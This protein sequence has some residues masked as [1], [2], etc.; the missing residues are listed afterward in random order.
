M[1]LSRASG[2]RG[3]RRGT[4]VLAAVVLALTGASAVTTTAAP[5]PAE[6]AITQQVLFRKGT[7]GYGCYRIPAI[8]RTNANTLLAFAEAR[9][10]YC[11]DAGHIDLVM[12]R[13][14]D[15]GRT[16]SPPV[17]QAPRIVLQGTDS[18]PTAAATRG[19]P[20]PIVGE[21]GRVVLLSTFNPGD[22]TRPRTPY[23][24]TSDDNGETWSAAR[25]LGSA[26]DDPT[27][28]WYAT[29][30]SHG[31]R[32]ERG[33]HAGRLVAGVNFSDGDGRNG[34]ALV[35]S[36][37]GGDT[38]VR[39]ATDIRTDT[40]LVPQEL[41]LFER[42]DGGIYAAA[43]DNNGA[44]GAK[45]A[46]AVS[47]DGGASFDAPF[48]GVADV[49]STPEVQGS[50]LRLR[51]ADRGDRYNRVLLASPADPS[52]RKYL[53]I[54]SS[55]DEGRTWTGTTPKRIASD[56]SGYSD[57]VELATGEI[58]ALYEGGP[59]SGDARDEIRFTR[60]TESDLGL[61]DTYSGTATPDLSGA[62]ND[63]YL[64]GG[65]ALG[66]AGRFDEAVTLDGADDYL[67]LPFSES[68]AIGT[69]DFTAMA[70]IRYGASTADQAIFWGYGQDDH[71]Q[72]WLRA[73]P[74]S[75]RIRGL[76]QSG[77]TSAV[78]AS[79][80]A[81]NDNAWHHVALQ[82][83]AGQLRLWVDGAVV[84]SAAAPTGTIS[85]GRPFR[86]YA[87]QRLDGANRFKG[88]LDEVRLYKRALSG[89]EIGA[90]RGANAIDVP[91]AVLRLPFVAA[92]PSTPDTSGAGN[93]A[94]VRGG[95]ALT[96]GRYGSALALDGADD[97]VQLPFSS[98]LDLGAGDFTVSAWLRYSG[99]TGRH[100][101]LWAYGLGTDTAQLWLRAHPAENR[102]LGWAETETASG[103]A[104]ST[105]GYA[106]GAWHHV[107]FQ[108][109]G[110]ELRLLV[111]GE[112]VGTAAAPAG[113]LTGGHAA[114]VLGLYLGQRPDGV[115]RLAGALDEV[116]IFRRALST[117]ELDQIRLGNASVTDGLVLRLPLDRLDP[118]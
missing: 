98:S 59:E 70:W 101:L 84:A 111:D 114:G 103:L 66:T 30:P 9:V 92:G 19:N 72:F 48:A 76:I 53:T 40:S 69:S 6:A 32:L 4:A 33:P 20:V 18:N 112:R 27:W 58:A 86:M 105:S 81:Y 78:V 34:A 44:T 108:R 7:F 93:T 77:G 39:G 74:G 56:R 71:S 67:H 61:P 91:G 57:L 46:F 110:G 17:D 10:S 43:R 79:T 95:A 94:F 83:A 5:R 11:G 54:W 49:A 1:I 8:V 90:I 116:R 73:E 47:T 64:R 2:G 15:N 26:I 31:I 35:Y 12:R 102:V 106:D 62:G 52:L 36:D 97:H 107:A 113:S 55:Y 25:S 117:A 3:G 13:S 22:A 80:K 88:Q 82:R 38:W 96:S 68:L 63:A 60:F 89:T 51:A 37:D 21:G 115:D 75:S 16:W 42:T 45:R 41:S 23:V 24:Q 100:T 14:T 65:A 118:A 109:A 29:G 87:G 99:G 50:T 28:G 85:P 104:G